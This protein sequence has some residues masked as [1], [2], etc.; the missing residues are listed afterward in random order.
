M[1]RRFSL[2]CM[3]EPLWVATCG[4]P[5]QGFKVNSPET[6]LVSRVWKKLVFRVKRASDRLSIPN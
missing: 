6:L 2:I 1:A 5:L 3:S 4:L